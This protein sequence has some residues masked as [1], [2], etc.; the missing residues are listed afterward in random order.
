MK[1]WNNNYRLKPI[2]EVTEVN[3]LKN[4]HGKLL[5]AF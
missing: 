5:S 1:N 2:I 4:F 3:L